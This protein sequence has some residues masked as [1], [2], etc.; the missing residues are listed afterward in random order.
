MPRVLLLDLGEDDVGA[1]VVHVV[2]TVEPLADLGAATRVVEQRGDVD[3]RAVV[4][5]SPGR[6]GSRRANQGDHQ[7]ENEENGEPGR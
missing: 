3:H 4:P 7:G 1:V 2:E 6:G 5:P